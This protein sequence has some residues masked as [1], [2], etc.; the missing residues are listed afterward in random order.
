[1]PR[2]PTINSYFPN[3]PTP[4]D[5]SSY[6]SIIF[7]LSLC[8]S[9]SYVLY[10]SP[11]IYEF[12]LFCSFFLLLLLLCLLPSTRKHCYR[13]SSCNTNLLLHF[14]S[15]SHPLQLS[16]KLRK[17]DN[18]P[19]RVSCNVYTFMAIVVLNGPLKAE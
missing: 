15:S 8:L 5:C 16:D 7:T 2:A 4:D 3:H 9:P 13:P 17:K 12:S 10:C 6:T 19:Y 18:H 14:P 11:C 1:M